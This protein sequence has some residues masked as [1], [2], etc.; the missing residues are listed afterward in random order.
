ML[1]IRFGQKENPLQLGSV[2]LNCYILE[3]KMRVL[4]LHSIQ[5]NLGYEGKSESWVIEFINKLNTFLPIDSDLFAAFKNAILIE[6]NDIKGKKA[7]VESTIESHHLI[8]LCQIIIKAKEEGFLKIAHLKHAKGAHLIVK[9]LEKTNIDDLIDQVTGF[10]RHKIVTL[11]HFV[12]LLK[13]QQNDTAVDWIKTIPI[14]FI[15]AILEANHLFWEDVQGKPS[16]LVDL[17]NE[18]IFSRI[19]NDVLEAIRKSKP[20]RVYT[21]KNNKKQ[22][23]EHPKLKEYVLILNSLLKASGK[24]WNIFIQLLNKAYPKQKFFK[25]IFIENKEK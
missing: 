14:D 9:T 17:L 12:T 8:K 5:K 22:E 1:K 25:I 16:A 3:N 20:K 15:E 10:T 19:E 13:N 23:I 4:T 6:I 24:N 11:E 21:R 2:S 18:I 7:S